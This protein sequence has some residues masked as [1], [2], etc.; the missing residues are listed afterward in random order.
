MGKL[1]AAIPADHLV[2]KINSAHRQAFGNAKKAMEYAAECGRLLLEAKG[3]VEHGEWLPWLDAHT[4]VSERQSQRYM[5]LAN[6][7]AEIEAKNDGAS[8]LGIDEAL[9][10][11]AKP[12]PEPTKPEPDEDEDNEG[13]D[14]TIT[15]EPEPDDDDDIL[16]DDGNPELEELSDE[17]A[18]L[19]DA[20]EREWRYATP[21]GRAECLE[22][23][24]TDEA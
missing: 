15:L 21:T 10:L 6:H 7:W 5:R 14:E 3:L 20:F 8:Y 12:R 13:D 9:K 4:E 17:D 18:A 16:G 22:F 2:T 19:V 11:V 24:G 23:V 1:A